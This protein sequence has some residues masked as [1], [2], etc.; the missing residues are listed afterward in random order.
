[1]ERATK[2]AF[3]GL[4]LGIAVLAVGLSPLYL[5]ST[6]CGTMVGPLPPSCHPLPYPLVV[7]FSGFS[8]VGAAVIIVSLV[9]LVYSSRNRTPKGVLP[10]VGAVI[11]LL[12][13]LASQDNVGLAVPNCSS[14]SGCNAIP[15]TFPL[16]WTGALVLAYSVL[17]LGLAFRS[18][19]PRPST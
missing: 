10:V 5:P 13:L 11:G 16:L 4:I 6:P 8:F 18:P 9:A 7:I 1:M 2:F 3:I 14:P 17:L 12:L 19:K 15:I